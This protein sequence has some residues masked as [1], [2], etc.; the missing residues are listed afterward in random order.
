MS[1]ASSNSLK[2]ATLFKTGTKTIY[3][4]GEII[5]RPDAPPAG[6]YFIESG[7]IKSY[8]ITKYGEENQLVVRGASQ[9][10]PI[11]WTMTNEQAAIYYEAMSDTVLYKMNRDVYLDKLE[12]DPIF[13]KAVLEQVLTMYEI[14]SQRIMNL[15]YRTTPERIAYRLLTLAD[16]F[17]QKHP[18]GILIN[19][20]IRRQDIAESVNCSRETASRELSKMHKRKLISKSDDGH[21]VLT[22]I[23]TLLKLVGAQD[24]M[25]DKLSRFN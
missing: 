1:D 13:T 11:I 7:F 24:F 12:N 5:I 25:K 9:M 15:E 19:A 14:H 22:K 21:I 10:F 20:P 6:V 8:D 4:K 2:L 18:M 23:D 16:R 3:K 17:G